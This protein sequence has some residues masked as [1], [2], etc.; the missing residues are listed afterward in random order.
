MN[1]KLI[2]DRDRLHSPIRSYLIES[3]LW[4]KIRLED[5]EECLRWETRG[6]L[7][8]VEIWHGG[9]LIDGSVAAIF[10]RLAS[11]GV[12]PVL[13][14]GAETRDQDWLTAYDAIPHQQT[15]LVLAE[16]EEMALLREE[17]C[18]IDP[19]VMGAWAAFR[20]C[21]TEG[22]G[23]YSRQPAP[24]IWHAYSRGLAKWLRSNSN[25]RRLGEQSP[26]TVG[27]PTQLKRAEDFVLESLSGDRFRL[28]GKSVPFCD[29]RVNNGHFEFGGFFSLP[30]VMPLSQQ[31]YVEMRN[32]LAVTASVSSAIPTPTQSSG[33]RVAFRE[34]IDNAVTVVGVALSV[35]APGRR[36][37]PIFAAKAATKY[38]L[39][40]RVVSISAE[41]KDA[42]ILEISQFIESRQIPHYEAFTLTTYAFLRARQNW[43][44]EYKI[45]VQIDDAEPAVLKDLP[46]ETE[47]H[48]EVEVSAGARVEYLVI[49]VV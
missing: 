37:G 2:N 6:G 34:I 4:A 24:A 28:A 7:K 19:A 35:L 46:V 3:Q 40:T 20:I 22:I 42:P 36:A 43:K 1:A 18:A 47:V 9:M 5:S 48:L 49:R 44:G 25:L 16:G 10:G 8:R 30:S 21:R 27:E 38:R 12:E 39:E 29:V 14:I 15:M 41:S 17:L 45:A 26:T 23:L 32:S 11:A 13:V 31:W 33:Q